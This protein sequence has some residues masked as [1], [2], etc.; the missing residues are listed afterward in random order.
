MT[1]YANQLEINTRA[2]AAA[3][4][5]DDHKA[6]ARHNVECNNYQKL[7]DKDMPKV[8]ESNRVK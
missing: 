3:A 8:W 6:E 1:H 2:Q 7:I 4:Y 5:I